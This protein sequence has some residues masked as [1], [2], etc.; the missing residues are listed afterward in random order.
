MD[1]K[2]EPLTES[3]YY[4]LLC[5]YNGP[6]HGYGIIQDTLDLTDQR[7]KIGSGT[8]Y[9]AISNMMKKGWIIER[10]DQLNEYNRKRLYELTIEGRNIL[11]EEIQRIKELIVG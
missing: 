1:K 2:F 6:N 11:I 9:G 8:M 10:I 4:I 5:L 7:L 3:Y